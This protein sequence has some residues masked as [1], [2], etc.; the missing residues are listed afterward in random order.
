[1]RTLLTL[2]FALL[3]GEDPTRLRDDLGQARSDLPPGILAFYRRATALNPEDRYA[4]AAE[5][6][7]ALKPLVNSSNGRPSRWVTDCQLFIQELDQAL[8]MISL[9]RSRP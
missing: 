7:E 1:M 9:R 3:V 6:R 2:M 8:D 4:S 5:M